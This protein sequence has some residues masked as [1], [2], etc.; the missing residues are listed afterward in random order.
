MKLVRAMRALRPDWSQIA[1]GLVGALLLTACSVNNAKKS[2]VL[3]EK[4]WGDGQ[5]AAAVL[6]FERAFAKDPKGKVGQQALYRAALTQAL[7]LSQHAEAIRKL[8]SYAE[9]TDDQQNLWEAKKLIGDLLFSKLEDYGHADQHYRGLIQSNPKAPEAPEFLFRVA[10]SRF[11]LG[12]FEEAIT[13]FRQLAK[14]RTKSAW[15]ER[16]AFEIGITYFTRGEQNTAG[17]T[18]LLEVYQE[19]IDAYEE[20]IKQYPTS[21]LIPEAKFGIASCLEELDQLDAAYHAYEGLLNS[22]PSPKVIQIKL[23]RIRERKAQRNR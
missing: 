15:A 16:A 6:E 14:D 1:A 23:A 11:F 21:A 10:K 18:P 19:A 20:F 22:Y 9:L 13:L 3:A 7:F 4:F 12:D 17:A 5:Y 8:K 2:Y